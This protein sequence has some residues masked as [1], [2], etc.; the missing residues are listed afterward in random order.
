[1]TTMGH[2]VPESPDASDNP[3]TVP[4]LPDLTAQ[5]SYLSESDTDDGETSLR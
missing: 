2:K 3:A 4:A 1:M 5:L